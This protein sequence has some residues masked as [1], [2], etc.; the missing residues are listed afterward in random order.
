MGVS[1]RRECMGFMPLYI[2]VQLW[3]FLVSR[4]SQVL[5]FL[6]TPVPKSAQ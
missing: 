4:K 6:G 2:P 1:A 3:E 5:R